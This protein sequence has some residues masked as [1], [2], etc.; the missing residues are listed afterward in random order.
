LN[1]WPKN[2][3]A[4]MPWGRVCEFLGV[5]CQEQ[6]LDD[7]GLFAIGDAHPELAN[8]DR[9]LVTQSSLRTYRACPRRY[10]YKYERGA[11]RVR[12]DPGPLRQG[13]SL[14]AALECLWSGQPIEIAIAALDP[15]DTFAKAKETAMI[16]G[17]VAWWGL[18]PKAIAVEQEFR[19]PLINPDTGAASRTFEVGGKFDAI[20][21]VDN[22]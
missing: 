3:D 6:S 19:M 11:R 21:E 10:H 4:C 13:K 5:C 20:A 9:S 1:V 12:D 15:A 8:N 22:E 14:H 2:P 16:I 7:P 18:P 17:Y